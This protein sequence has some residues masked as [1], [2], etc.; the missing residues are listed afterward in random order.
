MKLGF[1]AS[2]Y[3]QKTF[4]YRSALLNKIWYTRYSDP[5][6]RPDYCMCSEFEKY[7]FVKIDVRYIYYI[8]PHST[9]PYRCRLTYSIYLQH[10]R[11]LLFLVSHNSVYIY[12]PYRLTT[13]VVVVYVHLLRCKKKKSAKSKR[14]WAITTL[15]VKTE[16]AVRERARGEI[17]RRLYTYIRYVYIDART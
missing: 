10:H 14:G 16:H 5:Y 4:G 12:T 8:C 11:A 13:R 1:Y 9:I 2:K 17:K 6:Q 3:I 7:I 15:F